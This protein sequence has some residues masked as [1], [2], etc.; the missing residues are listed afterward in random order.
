MYNPLRGLKKIAEKVSDKMSDVAERKNIY[1][2]TNSAIQR[3]K[4]ILIALLLVSQ[5][6]LRL[7]V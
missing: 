3:I 2:K 7:P 1:L 5:I 4:S 6:A